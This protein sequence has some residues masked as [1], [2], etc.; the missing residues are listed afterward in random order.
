MQKAGHHVTSFGIVKLRQC[1]PSGYTGQ[2]LAK[3]FLKLVL[4]SFPCH[5]S[6]LSPTEKKW[7]KCH[8]MK[9]VW[10]AEDGV[11]FASFGV[12]RHGLAKAALSQSPSPPSPSVSSSKG[13]W[14]FKATYRTAQHLCGFTVYKQL[15]PPLSHMVLNPVK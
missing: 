7:K 8:K 9:K 14:F 12:E 5:T 2:K 11:H 4:I 13:L 6:S 15:S 3:R 1:S 10:F